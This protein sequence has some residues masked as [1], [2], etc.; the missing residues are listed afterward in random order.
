MERISSM[1]MAAGS[2]TSSMKPWPA[3]MNGF[4]TVSRNSSTFS[5][6]LAARSSAAA[7]SRRKMMLAAPSA[8]MTAISALGNASTRS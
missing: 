5:C 7:M 2:M 6:R 3:A 8:P 1:R 4:I